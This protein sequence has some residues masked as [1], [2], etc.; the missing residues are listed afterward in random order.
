MEWKRPDGGDVRDVLEAAACR[1]EQ[2]RFSGLLRPESHFLWTF[3]N[4]VGN[5][6]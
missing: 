4:A 3:G 5:F 6:S 2:L 1:I